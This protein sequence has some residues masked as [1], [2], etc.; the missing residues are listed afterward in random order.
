MESDWWCGPGIDSWAAAPTGCRTG[1]AG[2]RSWA[3][4]RRASLRACLRR[5]P[6]AKM[7][8]PG[9]ARMAGSINKLPTKATVSIETIMMPKFRVGMNALNEKMARPMPI[10]P[11]L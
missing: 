9:P 10:T 5:I 3:A 1:S 7:A 8:P 4:C 6:Q 11:Q 2:A